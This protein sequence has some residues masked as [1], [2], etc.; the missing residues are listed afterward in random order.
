MVVEVKSRISSHEASCAECNIRAFIPA[1]EDPNWD[2]HY[3]FWG[4]ETETTNQSCEWMKPYEFYLN[5]YNDS[6]TVILVIF[7]YY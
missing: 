4:V 2:L 1:W 3:M 6:L 7:N 5:I